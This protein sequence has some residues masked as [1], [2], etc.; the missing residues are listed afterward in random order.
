MCSLS[1]LDV[2]PIDNPNREFLD[3]MQHETQVLRT[4]W[5]LCDD[6]RVR[7]LRKYFMN[8]RPMMVGGAIPDTQ[9][10]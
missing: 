1:M 9:F 3:M 4:R 10:R 7:L 6:R 2:E 5:N 8:V